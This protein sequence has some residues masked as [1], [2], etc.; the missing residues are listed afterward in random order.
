MESKILQ[1]F[2]WVF[3][4]PNTSTYIDYFYEKFVPPTRHT[5]QSRELIDHYLDRALGEPQV[6][7]KRQSLVVSFQ[8]YNSIGSSRQ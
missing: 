6:N 5:P 3:M 2:D 1:F 7:T 8:T 4:T